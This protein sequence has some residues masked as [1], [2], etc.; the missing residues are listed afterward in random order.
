MRV[1]NSHLD[2]LRFANNV[3]WKSRYLWPTEVQGFLDTVKQA[4][5]SRVQIIPSDSRVYRAQLGNG[6]GELPVAGEETE[7]VP[8]PYTADRMK[9]KKEWTFED[10]ASEG[11]VNAKGIPCLYAAT[12][13]ETA[14]AEQ[15]PWKGSHVTVAS[16]K[17]SRELRIIN[18][19]SDDSAKI[20]LAKPDGEER[21]KAVWWWIDRAFS[22]PVNRA[23]DHTEYVPTQILAE[24]FRNSGI[25]G[26]GYRSSLG[27][28]YNLAF[29]D[30]DAAGV[31]NRKLIRSR[32]SV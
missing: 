28:G 11:R 15:R 26:I 23:D 21:E 13:L 22:E 4:S 10:G 30:L 3:R 14:I 27:P 25:D 19:T 7:K 29:F 17:A 2:Y 8:V 18:C 20:Y 12:H 16:L 6:W 5:G 24:L 9:P 32:M 1:F 31:E